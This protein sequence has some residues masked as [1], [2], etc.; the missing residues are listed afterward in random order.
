MLNVRKETCSVSARHCQTTKSLCHSSLG[1]GSV[2][3][4]SRWP[5]SG[6]WLPIFWSAKHEVGLTSSILACIYTRQSYP[7]VFGLTSLSVDDQ[8]NPGSVAIM[9]QWTAHATNWSMYFLHVLFVD[10]LET[11]TGWYQLGTLFHVILK[12][13]VEQWACLRITTCVVLML[14]TSAGRSLRYHSL[15]STL[16]RGSENPFWHLC[17]TDPILSNSNHA[18]IIPRFATGYSSAMLASSLH[19]RPLLSPRRHQSRH[20]TAHGTL[21]PERIQICLNAYSGHAPPPSRR[22]V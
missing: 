6:G 18:H 3:L 11:F 20:F 7:T 13:I 17:R 5:I 14:I 2:L 8:S 16:A 19:P 15:S 4:C 12:L 10:Q 21:Y 22:I 9:A 1:I